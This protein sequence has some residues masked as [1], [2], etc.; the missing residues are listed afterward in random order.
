M[1]TTAPFGFRPVRNI[2]GSPWNGQT[3]ACVPASG[4]AIF[5]GDIVSFNG[6]A[7]TAN[8]GG[9][10]VVGLPTVIRA[11]GTAVGQD[12]AG[13]VVGFMPEPANLNR[14][15]MGAVAADVK[16]A[17]VAPATIDTVFESVVDE[18]GTVFATTHADVMMNHALVTTAGSTVT[19][20]S[21]MMVQGGS[22][23]TTATLPV[24]VLGFSKLLC[25]T[26]QSAS[27]TIATT[28]CWVIVDVIFNTS[29]FAP[30]SVG[31]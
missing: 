18:S 14:T 29:K 15:H 16:V 25:N 20:R 31:I 5:V 22:A 11:T 28:T 3:I 19:G 24:R 10:D 9:V 12:I 23:N 13:V 7:A 21:N 26:V 6:S 30:N 8:V 27:T 4:T 1:S 2:N 17:L